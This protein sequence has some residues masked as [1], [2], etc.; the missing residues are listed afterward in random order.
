MIW[1]SVTQRMEATA[2]IES[3]SLVLKFRIKNKS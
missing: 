1:M 3:L 2:E